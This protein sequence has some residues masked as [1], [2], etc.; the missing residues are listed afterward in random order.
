MAAWKNVGVGVIEGGEDCN[1]LEI[2]LTLPDSRSLG[3]PSHAPDIFPLRRTLVSL[4]FRQPPALHPSP[5]PLQLF[6]HLWVGVG[7]RMQPALLLF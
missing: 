1:F 2:H 3:P 4:R 5:P 7:S 6:Q